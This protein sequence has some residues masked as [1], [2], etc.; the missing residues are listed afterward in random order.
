VFPLFFEKAGGFGREEA[1]RTQKQRGFFGS[2]FFVLGAGLKARGSAGLGSAY[3]E[4][5]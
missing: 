4:G 2:W 1:Q 3:A 5:R